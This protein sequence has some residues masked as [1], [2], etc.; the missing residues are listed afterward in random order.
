MATASAN[1]TKLEQ[2]AAMVPAEVKG[3]LEAAVTYGH[4]ASKFDQFTSAAQEPVRLRVDREAHVGALATAR[5]IGNEIDTRLVRIASEFRVAGGTPGHPIFPPSTSTLVVDEAK[6][7]AGLNQWGLAQ[8]P[9]FRQ[10]GDGKFEMLG[11]DG[12]WYVVSASPPIGAPAL[13]TSEGTIDFENPQAGVEISAAVIN[14]MFGYSRGPQVRAPGR[15][16]YDHLHF[17][18]NGIPI[19]TDVPGD[20][21]LPQVPPGAPGR[22][23]EKPPP[24]RP[25]PLHPRVGYGVQPKPGP[26][27]VV[28]A[29]AEGLKHADAANVNIARTHTTF[30]MDPVTGQRIAVV[31]AAAIRYD[32]ETGEGIV[33][34]GRLSIDPRGRLR[35]VERPPDPDEP[36]VPGQSVENATEIRIPAKAAG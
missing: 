32:N 35:V 1:P 9:E 3:A 7:G 28:G 16:T 11:P 25:E 5:S 33:S 27:F 2:A 34:W 31:N 14:G 10:R 23:P 4:L 19:V 30:Y 21:R 20:Q 15:A 24:M 29:I 18:E 6:V 26:G 17:D 13:G 22:G 12:S 8:G 36:C